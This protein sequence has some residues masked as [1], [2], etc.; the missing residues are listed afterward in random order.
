MTAVK[1]IR[2]NALPIQSPSDSS[3]DSIAEEMSRLNL[4][5][6]KAPNNI[7]SFIKLE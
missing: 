6:D 1:R 4:V 3:H 5:F 7:P 2:P